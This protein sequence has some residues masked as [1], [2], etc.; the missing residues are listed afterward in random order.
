MAFNFGR[1]L[2]GAGTV[3]Q[4]QR[5]EEEAQRVAR[6][7]QL[8]LEGLQRADALRQLQS[9][10]QLPTAP[11][12]TD[13][14]LGV[15]QQ[16]KYPTIQVQP[17]PQPG[18]VTIT[19]VQAQAQAQERLKTTPQIKPV[20]GSTQTI[21]YGQQV[22]N[23]QANPLMLQR[24]QEMAK[25]NQM[26]VDNINK[27]LQRTDLPPNIR[28]N[29][30]GQRDLWQKQ[31]DA[32]N[33]VITRNQPTIDYGRE[34][35]SAMIAQQQAAPGMNATTAIRNVLGREGGLADNP[36]DRGGLTKFGISKRA[37]PNLDI[38]SLTAQQAADIYKRDFWDAI[39]ADQL[40]PA[41]REMAFDAA[42]NQGVNWTKTALEQAQGNPAVFLQLREQRYRQ[43]AAA[44]PTQQQFLTGWLN[45][46]AEFQQPGAAAP[47]QVATAPA[48]T[49]ATAAG[50]QPAQTVATAP[51]APAAATTQETRSMPARL[52]QPPTTGEAMPE[53]KTTPGP[54]AAA[55]TPG[56]SQTPKAKSPTET[57]MA[58][59]DAITGDEKILSG[60]FDRARAELVRQ[61]KQY[62]QVGMGTQAAEVRQKIMALDE[63]FTSQARLLNAMRT[64]Y[65]LEYGNDPRGV[66]AAV[67][68][69]SG[70]QVAF[71]PRS[72]GNFDMQMAGAD[73]K[74]K[75]VSAGLSKAQVRDA[76]REMFD[77][78]FREATIAAKAKYAE[79]AGK[80]GLEANVELAKIKANM[81]KDIFVAREKGGWDLKQEAMKQGWKV[82]PTGAADGSAFITP[83]A[84]TGI[85]PFTY[86]AQGD[87][88]KIDG[89]EITT[90]GAKP[91][92]GL[93]SAVTLAGGQ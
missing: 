44:D 76:A 27:T 59:P 38:A 35:R 87:K 66:S 83:P 6:E 22:V 88:V 57:Y 62:Q 90:N 60:Q 20:P 49:P 25:L 5:V 9:Q 41:I 48:A 77:A 39:K 67:S 79:E 14:L 72:D 18:Q 42:V 24:A 17:E 63:G 61:F 78:K 23:P 4:A 19:P 86:S 10:D 12:T 28:K 2:S 56:L 47:T 55:A 46:L 54:L 64:V 81:V 82:T 45:R 15:G 11:V 91:I 75:T 26:K 70:Q 69:Y 65:A 74:M 80:K 53:V 31:L 32:N 37:Y 51:T 92:A 68:Y 50:T 30:E 1:L 58:N 89:V 21:P 71:V 73:G 36:A 33:Q 40:P 84:Y 7:N 13:D 43:I 3:G 93:P 34:G 52:N 16:Q 29:L 8:K 85:A